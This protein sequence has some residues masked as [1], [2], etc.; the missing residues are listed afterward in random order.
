M[1]FLKGQPRLVTALARLYGKLLNR[2]IDPM[3]EVI[4]TGGACSALFY[5]IMSNISQGEEV[6][7]ELQMKVGVPS[8]TPLSR[9]ENS[10]IFPRL[11]R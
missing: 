8:R 4:V 6:K 2:E 10:K 7:T 5:T 3:R 9:F 11:R 1:N